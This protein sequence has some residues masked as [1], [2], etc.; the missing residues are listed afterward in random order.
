MADDMKNKKRPS[1]RKAPAAASTPSPT[2]SPAEETKPVR[3][4]MADLWN[5]RLAQQE[6]FVAEAQQQTALQK[7]E[8]ERMARLYILAKLDPKGHVLACEER[9]Q[10]AKAEAEAAAKRA[11]KAENRVLLTQ[12]RME[13]TIGRPIKNLGI[14]LDTGEVIFPPQE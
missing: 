2:S 9:Q 10:K 11:E 4:K 14:D 13:D 3:V 1:R 7:A 8:T 5:M 12:K 6:K